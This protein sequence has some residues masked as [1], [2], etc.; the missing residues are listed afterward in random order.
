MPEDTT[1][2]RWELLRNVL[3]FQL[4]LA[5]DALRDVV[6]S[7]ISLGAALLDLVSGTDRDP[8]YFE[9]VLTL[10]RRTEGW[11]NLFGAAPGADEGPGIDRLVERVE[12][13]VVEQYERGGMT[14]QAKDA[15]DRS[16]DVLA[17]RVAAEPA[18]GEDPER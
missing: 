2:R 17:T 6:L 4:K 10:G 13:L 3:A 15:I 9:Q 16:L 1:D 11:I 7:P 18:P 12:A 8:L 14:A 5:V